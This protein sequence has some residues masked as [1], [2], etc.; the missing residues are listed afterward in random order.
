MLAILAHCIVIY[1]F[2]FAESL[3]DRIEHL[4][5]KTKTGATLWR[6]CLLANASQI[7]SSS[8]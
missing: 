4:T 1:D 6:F 3:E 5:K 2:L 8:L 7:L